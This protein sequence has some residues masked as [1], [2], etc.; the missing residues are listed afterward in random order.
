[1]YHIGS[2]APPFPVCLVAIPSFLPL[3]ILCICILR[4]RFV[5]AIAAAAT[6]EDVEEVL[7][8][9][10]IHIINPSTESLENSKS[11]LDN[12]DILVEDH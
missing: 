12:D 7:I 4:I 5:C 11:N 10:E 1:M 3:L 8:K 9:N 6:M 2:V